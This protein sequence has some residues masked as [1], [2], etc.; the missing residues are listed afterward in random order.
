MDTVLSL[1]RD[2]LPGRVVRNRPRL[3]TLLDAVGDVRDADIRLETTA[4]FRGNLAESERPALDPLL[5]H[6]SSERAQARTRMLRTLDAKPTREWLDTLADQLAR[7]ANPTESA[8][9]RNAPA[10]TVVP[11]LIRKRYRKLR[12]C[13]RKLT[14][15]SSMKEFHKIRIRTKKLRYALEVVAPTY[16]KPTEQMLAALHKLQ[17]KLG[18]QH[19]SNVV[20]K[21]L[22]QL[23]IHPPANFTAATLFAMGRMAELHMREAARL[24]RKVTKPWRKVRGR[25]W[26]ALRSHMEKRREDA[27]EISD[28]ETRVGHRA[29]D[30]K[31]AGNGKFGGAHGGCA[32][33]NGS[34]P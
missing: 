20:A 19:D 6:L 31:A 9:A 4:T 3:K 7:A 24:S 8:S 14:P 13:T 25:R 30:H 12:K 29:D 15:R 10:L 34:S 1:F 33:P 5:Q 16:T 21:Y 22:T 32:S 27:G 23:A 11:D 28:K 18:T 17:N 2:F 26:Q